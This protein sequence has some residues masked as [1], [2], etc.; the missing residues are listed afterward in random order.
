MRYAMFVTLSLLIP[1]LMWD[2]YVVQLVIVYLALARLFVERRVGL[3]PQLIWAAIIIVNGSGIAL[4]APEFQSGAG[5]LAM[6]TKLW[7]TL[8][9]WFLVAWSLLRLRQEKRESAAGEPPI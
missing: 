3:G 7:A 1:S 6:S 9:V 2:H 8:A 4:D 5:I